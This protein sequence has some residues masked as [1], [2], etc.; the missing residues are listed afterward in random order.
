VPIIIVP[1]V[2]A[3]VNRT[4]PLLMFTIYYIPAMLSE[5]FTIKSITGEGPNMHLY[6][7]ALGCI[8]K[9][10]Q[11]KAASGSILMFG[12]TLPIVTIYTMAIGE[13]IE[14]VMIRILLMAF[15]TVSAQICAVG[16]GVSVVNLEK[17][18]TDLVIKNNIN[19]IKYYMYRLASGALLITVLDKIVYDGM[20]HGHT[21]VT[22]LAIVMVIT[23]LIP[24]AIYITGKGVVQKQLAEI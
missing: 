14:V 5:N 12:V 2:F 6:R 22:Q 21:R 11:I 8:S 18:Y 24:T 3:I 16:I 1:I 13:T 10:M 17:G 15:A 23:I 9:Y 4:S 19:K 7:N 20:Q